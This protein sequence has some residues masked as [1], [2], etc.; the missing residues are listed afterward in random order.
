MFYILVYSVYNSFMMGLGPD[1]A[2]SKCTAV[3]R[4]SQLLQAY[5]EEDSGV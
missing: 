5:M 4:L 1:V 3:L 2:T